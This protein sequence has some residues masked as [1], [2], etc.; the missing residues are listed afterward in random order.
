VTRAQGFR[1]AAWCAFAVAAAGV[2]YFTLKPGPS[3]GPF[4][5]WDKAQHLTAYLTLAFLAG[6]AAKDWRQAA[7]FAAGLAVAGY[8][9]EIVQL[10]VGRSYD[11]VDAAANA[12]GCA[13]GF[14]LSRIARR[15][16]ARV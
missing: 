11:L 15:I 5:W 10:Y 3:G 1:A 7:L 12:L 4:V 14:A 9:L 8:G 6:L 16:G 2:L 13:T